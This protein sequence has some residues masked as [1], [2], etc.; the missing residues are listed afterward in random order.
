M[1]LFYILEDDIEKTKRDQIDKNKWKSIGIIFSGV[2]I[3]KKWFMILTL[4]K[5]ET[6][7]LLMMFSK[8]KW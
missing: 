7:I 5:S 6:E 3:G 8:K 2:I 4:K 1:K